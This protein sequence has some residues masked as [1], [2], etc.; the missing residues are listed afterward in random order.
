MRR[1]RFLTGLALAGTCAVLAGCGVA[2][3]P[4]G[5]ATPTPTP[6]PSPH[7]GPYGFVLVGDFGTRDAPERAVAREAKRWVATRPFDAFVTLG[8]NVYETG[9]P[10]QF[11]ASWKPYG[12]VD[13]RGAPVLASLGNHDI[14]TRDGRP[15]MKFFHMPGRWYEQ[16]VGPVEI[17]VLDANQPGRWKQRKWLRTTLAAVT[18]PW[19]VVVFHQPAYSCGLHGSTPEVQDRW[20]PLFRRYHVD[21]VVNGHD[22]DYQR[23]APM[24]G[25]T[26]VV[27][28]AGG[29]SLYD[30]GPCPDGTPSP[31]ASN[32]AVHG[33]L[34]LNATASRLTGKAVATG[35]KVLD[36]FVLRNR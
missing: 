20:V 32:D 9:D 14:E 15:E 19:T 29:R 4:A 7:V 34:F 27:D 28:G 8:D 5:P 36:T 26:Y 21:L 3:G 25:V 35:G 24:H 30:V 6:S 16:E 12:W 2:A 33:F 23:F 13:Q 18:A 31:I 11:A 10:A 17:V 22:H 1:P